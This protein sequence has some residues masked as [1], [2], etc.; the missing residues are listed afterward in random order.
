MKMLDY[1]EYVVVLYKSKLFAAVL[2]KLDIDDMPDPLIM[3]H[4]PDTYS[5]LVYVLGED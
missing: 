2:Y 1:N 3:M 4:D 5:R